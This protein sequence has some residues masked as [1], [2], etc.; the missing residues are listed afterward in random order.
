MACT[1]YK[2]SN[3]NNENSGTQLHLQRKKKQQMSTSR[4]YKENDR[5]TFT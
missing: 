1:L 2:S 3:T 5:N 4:T